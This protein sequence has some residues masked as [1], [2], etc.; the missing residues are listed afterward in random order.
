MLTRIV[1]GCFSSATAILMS[2]TYENMQTAIDSGYLNLSQQ[3]P[4]ELAPV[5]YAWQSLIWQN[6]QENLWQA[7]GRFER[8]KSP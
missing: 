1:C 3:I 6:P 7:D 5:G 4:A 2:T 8:G